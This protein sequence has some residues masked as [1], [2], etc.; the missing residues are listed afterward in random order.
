M[1]PEITLN[2]ATSTENK[3]IYNYSLTKH[4]LKDIDKKVFF[5]AMKKQTIAMFCKQLP[6]SRF[7][8]ENIISE[9]LFYDK[10][11]KYIGNFTIINKDCKNLK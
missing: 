5:P 8:K 7:A 6:L 9:Y 4:T 3:I 10:N 2:G 11:N 1:S